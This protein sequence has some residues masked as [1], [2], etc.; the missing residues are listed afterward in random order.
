MTSAGQNM[1][2]S[3]LVLN[4]HALGQQQQGLRSNSTPVPSGVGSKPGQSL[5]QP[6]RSNVNSY[7]QMSNSGRSQT[8][9]GTLESKPGGSGSVTRVYTGPIVTGVCRMLTRTRFVVDMGYHAQ[10]IQL[11]KGIP[12]GKYDPSSKKWD[13]PLSEHSKVIAGI[14]SLKPQATVCPLPSF[15]LRIFK[16]AESTT[17]IPDVDLSRIDPVLVEALLPFQREGVCFGISRNGRVLIADDMGLGKTIQALGI[18]HY[19]YSDWPL[20]IVTPSSM[21]YGWRDSIWQWLPSVPGG[22]ICVVESKQDYIIDAKV[23]ILSYDLLQRRAEEPP[24]KLCKVVIMD[25]SHHLKNW[26][27]ARAKAATPLLQ[28]GRRAIL[29]SGTP[30]LSRPIELYT[31]ITAVNRSIF[32]S[33]NDFGVRYCA[34]KKN[35]WGWDHSGSSNMEELQILLEETIMIRRLKSEVLKQLPSKRRQMIILDPSLVRI[36]SKHLQSKATAFMAEKQKSAKHGKLLEYFS[37]SGKAKLDAVTNY[38]V[39]LVEGG[40][41]FL[42]FA[43]HR[44]VLD[45][46]CE[47]L[48][49]VKCRYIRID[50]TTASEERKKLCDIFQL[51]QDCLV[52]VLSITAANAGITLTAASLVLFAELFWNPGILTQAE[53]RVHRI[54]QQDCVMV[55][56]LLAKGT[57]DDEIWRLVADKLDVLN[58]AGLSKDNFREAN[59]EAVL[60]QLPPQEP[61]NSQS[62]GSGSQRQKAI[63]DYFQPVSSQMSSSKGASSGGWVGE[64]NPE[65]FSNEDLS[66]CFAT[67]FSPMDDPTDP[68]DDGGN[69][70]GFT[71]PDDEDF[72]DDSLIFDSV[73]A[74]EFSTSFSSE[75]EWKIENHHNQP[76]ASCASVSMGAKKELPSVASKKPKHEF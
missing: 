51:S 60:Q 34:G 64:E 17:R 26:K 1:T 4:N 65:D 22:S 20:L 24:I 23:I 29:L 70:D 25:E 37:E 69:D 63:N 47:A 57:A 5:G 18:A 61:T 48:E 50:G 19:Y 55:Q 39:D 40:K 56:Y 49:G 9:Q 28:N 35:A 67:D 75:A 13:F 71:F 32:P 10:T 54:G 7:P 2:L 58:K 74:H 62:S 31:Q 3:S 27:T 21:R 11:F 36:K 45:G 53:D 72:S 41:K 46:I 76:P 38:V 68:T 66:A 44:F 52:A 33:V 42:C 12:G 43:H 30:A 73:D 6:G 59:S 15:I 8:G 14:E 16:N